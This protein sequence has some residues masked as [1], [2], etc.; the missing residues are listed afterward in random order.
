MT[1]QELA[2]L[3]DARRATF[4]ARAEE[5]GARSRLV[6]NLRGVSFGVLAIAGLFALFGDNSNV[7]APIALAGLI[8]FVVL[9]IH[10]AR[11]IA[12]EEDARRF[13][14][15]NSDAKARVSGRWRELP[16]D[17]ARFVDP[18]HA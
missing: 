10:H 7:T 14:R 15:V 8:A 2:E 3:Y 11:V 4:A 18:N 6:S 9:V 1:R 13:A 12:A 17:G 16:E 5:L